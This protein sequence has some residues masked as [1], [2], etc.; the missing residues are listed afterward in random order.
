M[1]SNSIGESTGRSSL[2]RARSALAPTRI[3]TQADVK[4]WYKMYQLMEHIAHA[5]SYKDVLSSTVM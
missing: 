4:R 2:T 3:K 1:R 5:T